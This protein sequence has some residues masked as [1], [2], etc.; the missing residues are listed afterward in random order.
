VRAF[1]VALGDKTVAHSNNK[2]YSI[3][4]AEGSC[5][6]EHFQHQRQEKQATSGT[7]FKSAVLNR[8]HLLKFLVH[9]LY[10]VKYYSVHVALKY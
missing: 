9:V 4:L 10:I 6:R 2:V 8:S 1:I 7:E 5:V 3:E